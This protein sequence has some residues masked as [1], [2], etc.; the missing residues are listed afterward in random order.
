MKYIDIFI[1]QI[2]V[3]DQ[4]TENNDHS[5][6]APHPP[7]GGHD[8]GDR[9]EGRPQQERRE[10][11]ARVDA[12][13]PRLPDP[14]VS[15]GEPPVPPRT[16]PAV[17]A[18]RYPAQVGDLGT[19]CQAHRRGVDL[20]RVPEGERGVRHRHCWRPP[21]LPREDP[22]SGGVLQEVPPLP[23]P[24]HWDRGHSGRHLPHGHRL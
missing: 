16:L 12:L 13:L 20:P 7:E 21:S 1:K 22:H 23:P 11:E 9:D 2:R 8:L 24:L 18:P 17:L 3:Y 19:D 15:A 4:I 10:A 14:A 5:E 6:H